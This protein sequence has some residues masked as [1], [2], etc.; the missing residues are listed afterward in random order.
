M[1]ILL[2]IANKRGDR[3]VVRRYTDSDKTT[4]EFQPASG[5][6]QSFEFTRE[7]IAELA[8]AVTLT[9]GKPEGC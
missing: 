5:G 2:D 9:N 1:R 8:G 4:V 6:G 7:E 3:I